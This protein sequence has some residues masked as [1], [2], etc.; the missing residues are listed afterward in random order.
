MQRA[1]EEA[2]E[3]AWYDY[4]IVNDD[5]EEAVELVHRTIQEAKNAPRRQTEMIAEI[6]EELKKLATGVE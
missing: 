5:L 3:M 2:G 6:S 4:L 1:A